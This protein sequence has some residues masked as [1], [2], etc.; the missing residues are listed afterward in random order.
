MTNTFKKYLFLI[1]I[2]LISGFANLYANSQVEN[3]LL[4]KNNSHSNY[5]SET[6]P[7]LFLKNIFDIS[8]KTENDK[9][10]FSEF[11]NEENFEEDENHKLKENNLL[12]PRYCSKINISYARLFDCLH[13]K[14]QE[15]NQRDVLIFS[16]PSTRLHAKYQVFII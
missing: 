6:A 16:N 8:S 1:N 7:Q 5:S 14:L 12:F 13:C 15:S 4:L 10:T 11:V 3:T 2:L 9:K